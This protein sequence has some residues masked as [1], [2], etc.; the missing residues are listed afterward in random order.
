M[1]IAERC[2]PMRNV[3]NSTPLDING[4]PIVKDGHYV[5]SVPS[6]Y[7]RSFGHFQDVVVK[8][9][10]VD[11]LNRVVKLD[12]QSNHWLR[13]SWLRPVNLGP[14]LTLEKEKLT[15]EA[16]STVIKSLDNKVLAAVTNARGVAPRRR[17]LGKLAVAAALLVAGAGSFF[18]YSMLKSNTTVAA[19]PAAEVVV[20]PTEFLVVNNP[21]DLIH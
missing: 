17:V 11:A 14:V 19:A 18:G 13:T 3:S 21:A 1:V 10:N 4:N 2:A 20:A 5:V 6:K 15:Q 12:G 7:A 8:A 16:V 9:E